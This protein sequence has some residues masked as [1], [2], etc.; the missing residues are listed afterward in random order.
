MAF[1][2]RGSIVVSGAGPDDIAD[3]IERVAAVLKDVPSTWSV[4]WENDGR[5]D[6]PVPEEDA[7]A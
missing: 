2:M 3:V 5:D 4:V 6:Q 1:N 7:A